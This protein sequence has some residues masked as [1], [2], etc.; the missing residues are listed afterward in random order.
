ML[1]PGAQKDKENSLLREMRE[2]KKKGRVNK[3]IK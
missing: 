3:L 1:G 2:G